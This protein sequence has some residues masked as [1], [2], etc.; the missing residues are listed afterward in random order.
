MAMISLALNPAWQK[1]MQADI[2][3]MFGGKDPSEWA[4][5]ENVGKLFGSCIDAVISESMFCGVLSI[6]K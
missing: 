4:Y 5:G 6:T 1:H 2:D 3:K